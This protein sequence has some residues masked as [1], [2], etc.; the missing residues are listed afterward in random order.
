MAAA[1][2]AG[3]GILVSASDAFAVPPATANGLR[4]ALAGPPLERLADVLRVI[5]AVPRSA[6]RPG[7]GSPG[8]R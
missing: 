7:A 3:K 8:A 1:D 5:R 6:T 4:L 2:L